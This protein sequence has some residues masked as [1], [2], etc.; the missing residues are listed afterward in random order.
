MVAEI[1]AGKRRRFDPVAIPAVCFTTPEV[2]SV[3]A[4]PETGPEV[5]SAVFPLAANGRAL[6][7]EGDDDG[8]FIRI[9]ARAD[10]H[11]ILAFAAVGRHVS[12][13]SGEMTA[14]LEMGAVLED[15]AGLIH[16]HPTQ[17]EAIG[18]AALRALGHAIHI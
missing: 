8:G 14:L 3:G 1:I 2:V 11:R 18:E 6:S 9:A 13:L 15:A 16:A 17:S 4:W 5:V 7:Q 12:E 10:D